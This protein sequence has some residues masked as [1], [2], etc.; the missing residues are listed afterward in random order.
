MSFQINSEKPCHVH[1]IGIGG[2]SMSGLAFILREKGF[3][4]TGSDRAESIETNYLKNLGFQVWI[5]HDASHIT[6]D[7]GLLVYNAAIHPDNPEFAKAAQMNIPMLTRGELLGH[8]VLGAQAVGR[9]AE[10]LGT[11]EEKAVLLQHMLLS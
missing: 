11:P 1:F 3:H 2:M 4:V 8:P 9:I 7:V 5:G 6:E 10:E